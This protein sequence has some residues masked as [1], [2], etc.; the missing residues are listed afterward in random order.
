MEKKTPL[1]E[2]HLAAGGK[3]V[4]FGGYLMPVQYESGVIAEHIAVRTK[5][6]LFDVS[7]MAELEL[8]GSDAIACIQKLV[9]TDISAM[10]DGQV[11][12]AMLCNEHGGIIDDLVIYR[13]RVDNYL[14]VVNASNHE[15]DAAWIKSHLSGNVNYY[16]RSDS[17]GLLAIQGPNAKRIL[18]KL[19]TALPEK[20]YHFSQITDL[21]LVSR[22]IPAILSR[23]GYTG[24][25]GYEIYCA[26]A[27]TTDLWDALLAAG[28]EDGLIPCGLGARDTLRLEAGMPLYGHEINDDIS[29][30]EAGL[31]CQLHGK[32]FIG[33]DAIL[34]RGTPT[35]KRVGLRVMGRGIVREGAELFLKNGQKVG[36][37]TSGT[38]C[39]Y[40]AYAVAMAY[41]PIDHCELGLL[42]D[43]N[44]RGRL[45][46]TQVVPLPFYSRT[47]TP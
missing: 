16:D 37:V 30:N 5:A 43:A 7:H 38:H 42:V 45:I 29:P 41:L 20:Y 6:G 3:M 25:H 32:E 22:E 47:Q 34:A 46:E 18:S 27:D 13:L 4:E 10:S 28:T 40:L 26:A 33:R 15:K 39:P 1:Y 21:Q 14:L 9:T 17:I 31:P 44:V 24:E 12:Y 23:T 36:R 35:I 8:S 19:S 11:K 2:T